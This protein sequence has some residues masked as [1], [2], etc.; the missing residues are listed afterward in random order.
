M[1]LLSKYCLLNG[2][3]REGMSAARLGFIDAD[4]LKKTLAVTTNNSTSKPTDPMRRKLKKEYGQSFRM[5]CAVAMDTLHA[6]D[7]EGLMRDK[8]QVLTY[9]YIQ[10]FYALKGRNKAAS[11]R[12]YIKAMKSTSEIPE[13]V[14]WICRNHGAPDRIHCDPASDQ[15]SKLVTAVRARYDIADNIVTETAHQWQSGAETGVLILKTGM[16]R[17]ITM[18]KLVNDYDMPNK[19]R[20]IELAHYAATC[21][22]LGAS[23]AC[24]GRTPWE[25]SGEP[26]ADLGHMRFSFGEQVIYHNPEAAFPAATALEGRALGPAPSGNYLNTWIETDSTGMLIS[27]SAVANKATYIKS[28]MAALYS[29]DMEGDGHMAMPTTEGATAEKA[30]MEKIIEDSRRVKNPEAETGLHRPKLK[31]HLGLVI[32]GSYTNATVTELLQGG[33]VK[34]TTQ[35]GKSEIIMGDQEAIEAMPKVV[36][37]KEIFAIK[38]FKGHHRPNEDPRSVAITKDRKRAAGFPKTQKGTLYLRAA[39]GDGEGDYFDTF[40]PFQQMREDQPKMTSDYIVNTFKKPESEYPKAIANAVRWAKEHQALPEGDAEAEQ[41]LSE[42]TLAGLFERNAPD[43]QVRRLL[44]GTLS[45]PHGKGEGDSVKLAK[46]KLNARVYEP[47][48]NNYLPRTVKEALAYDALYDS[49]PTLDKLVKGQRWRDAINDEI[50]VKMIGENNAFEFFPAGTTMPKGYQNI[51][52]TTVF[53]TDRDGKFKARAC[54][55]GD[56]VRCDVPTYLHV[57]ESSSLRMLLTSALAQQLDI[58]ITDI[59]QAFLLVEPGPWEDVWIPKCGPEFGEHHGQA[60]RVAANIYGLNSAGSAWNYHFQRILESMGFTTS[61]LDR[62]VY[63]RERSREVDGASKTYVQM[64]GVHVDDAVLVAEDAGELAEEIRKQFQL[65]HVTKLEDGTVYLGSDY[66]R[67]AKHSVV[68]HTMQ[69]Y[70]GKTIH[71]MARDTDEEGDPKSC[72]N[73]SATGKPGRPVTLPHLVDDHPEDLTGPDS[74]L[75]D[76]KGI[77]RYQSYLGS[78]TWIAGSCRVDAEQT[79]AALA[80]FAACPAKGHARRLMICFAYLRDNCERGLAIDPSPFPLPFED[81]QASWG[82]ALDAGMRQA[83]QLEYG[84]LGEERDPADP[85]GHGVPL[86]LTAF[87]DSDHASDKSD[88]RSVTGITIFLNRTLLFFKSVKQVGSQ[89]SSYAAEL[90]ALSHCATV[91]RGLRAQL[92]A[93]SIIVEG[94]TPVYCDNASTVCASVQLGTSIRVKHLSLDYHNVRECCAWGVMAVNKVPSADNMADVL[95]KGTDPGT[96]KCLTPGLLRAEKFEEPSS[97]I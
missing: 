65:K 21:H 40:E 36:D 14:A 25:T 89:G 54:M 91:V 53:T 19:N 34:I 3:V 26:S 18:A 90:R 74:E 6:K 93:M 11:G 77:L 67:S 78:L 49:D 52:M 56:Q 43:A 35:D 45:N 87:V 39:W 94:P 71:L 8:G 20:W 73:I 15:N 27:R 10:V 86:S 33:R 42:L 38:G 5:G 1:D 4:K 55:R 80:S 57:M 82:L 24:G 95:T 81:Q 51:A 2:G 97:V 76:E 85:T 62:S 61:R 60:A 66:R 16:K 37:G 28:R 47:M 70:I 50:T 22:N 92:R 9:P 32:N 13:A 63:M 75:L 58:Q 79:R 68:L 96:F 84:N 59:K 83:L 88:R 72:F 31:A 48:I 23:N 12:I 64:I 44:H 30:A 7:I 46:L 69:S 17:I 29:A 41:R